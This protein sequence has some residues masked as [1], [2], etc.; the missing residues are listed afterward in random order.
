MSVLFDEPSTDK[1]TLA[2]MLYS[3]RVSVRRV[4]WVMHS[5]NVTWEK[6]PIHN[7]REV[8]GMIMKCGPCI[9]RCLEDENCASCIKALDA[10]DM[11]DQVLSY[12]TVVYESD[13]LRN[14]LLCILT[15]NNV[16]GNKL[17]LG[18]DKAFNASIAHKHD[19]PKDLEDS[20]IHI[21]AAARPHFTDANRVRRSDLFA[22]LGLMLGATSTEVKDVYRRLAQELHL[23]VSSLNPAMASG[24]FCLV[25][26]AY[27]ILINNWDDAWVGIERGV[28]VLD[29]AFGGHD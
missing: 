16:F 14:F 19:L 9:A 20:R 28:V 27:D 8:Y 29:M 17:L 13:L 22:I 6:G 2:A 11:R 5:I 26:E 7:T 25:R 1:F 10:I 21:I 18:W 12:R 23:D 24:C 15:K 3:D 4:P